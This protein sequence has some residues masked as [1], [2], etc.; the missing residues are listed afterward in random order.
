MRGYLYQEGEMSWYGLYTG[1]C[2]EQ[3]VYDQLAAQS[4]LAYLPRIEVWSRRLD[5][6]KKI[7]KPFFPGYLFVNSTMDRDHQV[8][9]L[10]IRGIVRIL[11]N[12]RGEPVPIAD[13]QIESVQQVL[14]ERFIKKSTIKTCISHK[15]TKAQRVIFFL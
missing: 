12:G 6:R 15:G 7:Q 10:G 11:G 4:F 5:R 2:H 9:I 14:V 8:K 3:R 1:S 13:E